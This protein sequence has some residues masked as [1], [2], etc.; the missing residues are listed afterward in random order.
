MPPA[1]PNETILLKKKMS[2]QSICFQIHSLRQRMYS[3]PCLVSL[4]KR[5]WISIVRF[6]KRSKALLESPHLGVGYQQWGWEWY[7]SHSEAQTPLGW[8]MLSEYGYYHLPAVSAWQLA[9]TIPGESPSELTNVTTQCRPCGPEQMWPLHNFS[10]H[11]DVCDWTHNPWLVYYRNIL[12][13][14]HGCLK[15]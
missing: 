4:E 7:R 11:G 14:W 12:V 8:H 13:N 1:W 9:E 6:R 2:M 3:S 10:P 5:Q 15:K